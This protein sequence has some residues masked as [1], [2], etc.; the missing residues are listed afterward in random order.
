MPVKERSADGTALAGLLDHKQP[1]VDGAGFSDHF[2]EMLKTAFDVKV[3]GAIDDRF[4]SQRA[5]V[6]EVL[7]DAG[8]LAAKLDPDLGANREDP[9]LVALPGQASEL[10]R[11][12]HRDFF[13]TADPN[14][15]LTS[16]SK[17]PRARRGSLNTSVREVSTWR[18]ESSHQ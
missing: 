10:A 12:D 15:V 4:D 7:L 14:V 2:G 17:K 11:E 5:A 6:F 8:V 13:G 18:I 3:V 1:R 16:A 9:V